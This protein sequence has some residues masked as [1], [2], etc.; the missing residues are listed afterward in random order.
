MYYPYKDGS[1]EIIQ[2]YE[3]QIPKIGYGKNRLT[4]KIEHISVIKRSTKKDEQ[5][6]ERLALSEDWEKRSKAESK[7]QESDPE[8]FDHEMED[9]RAMHWKYRLCGCWIMI[10]GK[11][12]Y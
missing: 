7:K 3:C 9:I 6:W 10:N 8:Y 1:V 2:G 11:E 5:Y 4:G 12:T